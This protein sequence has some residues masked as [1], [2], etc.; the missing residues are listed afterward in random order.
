MEDIEIK[1]MAEF[2]DHHWWYLS[3]HHK[4][5]KSLM[6]LRVPMD[7]KILDAGCGTGGLLKFLRKTGYQNL[8]GFDK[9]ILATKICRNENLDVNSQD[10]IQ[11]RKNYLNTTFDV[12]LCM[13][14]LYF[15]TPEEQTD[16][17][18]SACDLLNPGGHILINLPAFNIFSGIHDQSVGIK[19]RTNKQLFKNL[20]SDSHLVMLQSHYWP[21]C[22]SLFIAAIRTWQRWKL[23]HFHKRVIK[24]D[25]WKVPGLLNRLLFKISGMELIMP[26]YGC[27]GSSLFI[28][29]KK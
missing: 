27:F 8:Q 1:K 4:V 3:L 15:L 17:L 16:F 24:S 14:C 13:D 21:Y 11:L 10:L 6:K 9:S 12:I 22:T 20:L 7:A 28:V 19:N 26:G 29:L 25:L 5:Q 18:Q 23:I 2:E